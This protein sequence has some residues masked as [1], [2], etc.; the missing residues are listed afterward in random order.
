MRQIACGLDHV[1]AV[2]EDGNLYTWGVG[3]YGKLGATTAQ[4]FEDE[5]EKE[6]EEEEGEW[7]CGFLFSVRMWMREKRGETTE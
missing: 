3:E 1:A 7:G 2:T 4:H 5:E 6:E